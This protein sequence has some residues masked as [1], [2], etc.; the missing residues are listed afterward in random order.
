M[1]P[2]NFHHL[3]Y[4]WATAKEGNL[5]RASEKL[6]I[7]QPTVSAQIRALE[8]ALGEKL[9]VRAGRNLGLTEAGRLVYRYADEIFGLGRE[10]LLS[11]RGAGP[12]TADRPLRLVV[13]IADALPKLLAYRLLEPALNLPEPVQVTC[14]EDKPERLLAELA[15]HSFDL[16]LTDM[17]IGAVKVRAYS[18]LLGESSVEIFGARRLSARYREGF[19]A[20]LDGAPFLLPTENAALRR[21]LD[22][23]FEAKGLHPRVMGEFEDSSLLKTFGQAAVGL[24][25][26]PIAIAA[27][28]RAQYDVEG[29]GRVEGVRQRFYAVS[30]ERRIKHPAVVAISHAAHEEIFASVEA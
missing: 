15:T 24:F 2:L 22:G 8:E 20:S 12:R 19:P 5:T 10:M 21:S 11:L 25:A 29:I 9:F 14:Y 28:L 18:H 3:R 1:V 4:F 13:G 30:V 23:W 16:V 26:A 7:S 17:P 6:N 27:E